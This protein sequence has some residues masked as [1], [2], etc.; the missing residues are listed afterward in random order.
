MSTGILDIQPREINF[1]TQTNADWL[2]G[3]LIWQAGSGGVVP[4]PAN[5]GSGALTIASVAS[6]T[7]LGA[8]TVTVTSTDGMP[9]I[10]VQDPGG[11][12]TATGVVGLP[13][14]AGGITFTLAS[15]TPPL[16]AGDAFAIGILPVPL[17]ITGL[18]FELHARL[19]PTSANVVLSA[20]SNPAPGAMPT[21]ATGG[22]DGTIG[23]QVL[24]TALSRAA[25]PPGLYVYDI[26]A[27]DPIADRRVTAF[28]GTIRHVD[29]DTFLP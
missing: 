3:L 19:T 5:A 14:Y 22:A 20:A 15:G 17:D 2:D 25:F 24:R 27:I 18:Q 8:H 26:L 7:A 4:G 9:R 29:G 10:T 12:V 13:L 16:K 1:R 28:F 11:T 21:I 6:A 23:M